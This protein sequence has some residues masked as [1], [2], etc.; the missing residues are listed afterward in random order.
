MILKKFLKNHFQYLNK[1]TS[2]TNEAMALKFLPDTT[3]SLQTLCFEGLL[4]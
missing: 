1:P 4:N 2:Q 3:L